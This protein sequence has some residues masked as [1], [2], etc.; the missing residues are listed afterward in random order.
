MTKKILFAGAVVGFVALCA[1]L[2]RGVVKLSA[3][4]LCV[5]F[6]ALGVLHASGQAGTNA[7]FVAND[8]NSPVPT[9]VVGSV[10]IS[11][12]GDAVTAES[13]FLQGLVCG[14]G[15]G[16]ILF[17]FMMVRRALALGDNWND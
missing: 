11:D 7:V 15:L 17:G 8:T 3:P 13:Y 9:F 2:M 16:A 6:L 12:V 10:S 14:S 1:W 5:A 4:L